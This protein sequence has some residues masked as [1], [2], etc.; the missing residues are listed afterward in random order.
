[1]GDSRPSVPPPRPEP[2]DEARFDELRRQV[3]AAHRRLLD[4]LRDLPLDR[5]TKKAL[6]DSVAEALLCHDE[7][8]SLAFDQARE[9]CKWY[10]AQA[11]HY[12]S[13]LANQGKGPRL[14]RELV[15]KRHEK[16]DKAISTGITDEGALFRFMQEHHPDLIRTGKGKKKRFISP[17]QMMRE[18][19]AATKP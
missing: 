5:Q 14:Q 6:A 12:A 1:M 19:R 17:K 16:M 2:L 8:A 10:A 4:L 13:K 18:F 7:I 3:R 11:E 15:Q 9:Y